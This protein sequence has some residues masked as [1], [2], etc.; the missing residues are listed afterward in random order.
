MS[1]K[2][3]INSKAGANSKAYIESKF[4]AKNERRKELEKE[5]INNEL[6][7]LYK[8]I[9]ISSLKKIPKEVAVL[10]EQGQ[11]LYCQHREELAEHRKEE[12]ETGNL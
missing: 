10:W 4:W 12:Y 1:S 7:T 11:E 3:G 9:H 6:I 2:F 8:L 5:R